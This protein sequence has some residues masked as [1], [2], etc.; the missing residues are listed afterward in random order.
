M[1]KIMAVLLVIA[2]LFSFSACS[3]KGS[4]STKEGDNKV[5]YFHDEDTDAKKLFKDSPDTIDPKS[6]YSS[7]EITAEMLHG[8]YAVNDL[9][10]DI[11]KLSKELTFSDT[12][13][14][15]GTFHISSV[16]VAVYSGAEYL[17]SSESQFRAITD[18][19]VA[20]LSFIADGKIGTVPCMYEVNGNKI[21]YTVLNDTTPKGGD[22]SYEVD[23]IVFEYEFSLS[24]PY[25]T[26]T[27]GTDTI[28]LT[29]FTF[30]DNNKSTS[31]MI[32]AY[33]QEKTPLVD[34]MDYLISQQDSV[35]NVSMDRAG[36]YYKDSAC[37][38]TDDG[39]LTVYLLQKDDDG[40]ETAFFKQYA[41]IMQCRGVSYFNSFS[42]ILFDGEKTYY[43]N[44][45]ELD[46]E[47]RLLR[48]Q[49]VDTAQVEEEKLKE[50]AEKKS[51]LFD[52][53]KAEFEKNGISVSINRSTGELVM[54]ASVL[55]GGDSAEITAE[56]KAFLDNFV[57]AYTDIIYN[58]KYNGFIAKTVV[59]GHTAPVS[60]VSYE[61]GLPFS[62]KRAKNVME[63]CASVNKQLAGSMEA[64]G[65]SNSQPVY[66]KDGNIDFDASR[67]VT[68]RFV[69]NMDD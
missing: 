3:R 60:G 37:K 28:T 46:R 14:D 53:L 5:W 32:S 19:E 6:I 59:E 55:F 30:T 56:G 20:S 10:K 35:I 36:N 23:N 1:K 26:L 15:N 11:K 45:S 41:Y 43:Y 61:A 63:Y 40:N 62:E 13:F 4:K 8:A 17:Y 25:L 48:E 47:S 9:E 29:G 44:D 27:D 67:R 16:P 51:D 54:D 58:D 65:M 38:I 12:T 21:K 42:V 18:K 50:I 68:F 22:F 57:K 66:D 2:L 31:T 24:G 49:G 69:V 34:N 33:S 7:I 52:D 39:K 64:K